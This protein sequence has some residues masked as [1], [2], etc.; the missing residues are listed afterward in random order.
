MDVKLQVLKIGDFS[1]RSDER[2]QDDALGVSC[3]RGISIDKKFIDTKANLEGITLTSYKVVK[4][5]A[6][7]FVT[8]T[9]RNGE[10]IS[11]ALN[12]SQETFLVSATYEVF[13]IDSSIILPRFLY[14]WFQRP[15]FD[16]YARFHSWGSARETFSFEDMRRIEILVPDIEIQQ[17]LVNVW[18]GL[19]G[20][21]VDNDAQAEPLMGLCMSYLKK[22]RVEYPFRKLGDGLIERVERFNVDNQYGF[23]SVRGVSN[24]KEIIQTRANVSTRDLSTFL[25]LQKNEFIFNRRTTRNGERI[26]IGYNESDEDY[27]FTNDYVMFRVVDHDTLLP[28]FLYLCFKR[29]E[30]DRYARYHSWGSATELFKWDNMLQVQIPIPPIDVQRAVVDIYKCAKESKAISCEA[31]KL[32][33]AVAPALIQKAIHY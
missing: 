10:K 20:L 8:V 28:E 14:L 9:S 27:I 4:P 7:A 19:N 33:K 25:I 16:R 2:N 23:D 24:T 31:E 13:E 26:G 29:D 12:D 6:F 5:N 21:K 32:R 11:L 18:E 1:Q 17:Q 3:V 30:F 15:E 22:L